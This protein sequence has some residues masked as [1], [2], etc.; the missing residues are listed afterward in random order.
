[1][2]LGMDMFEECSLL[3][4]DLRGVA[5]SLILSKW[6]S[7]CG[8]N[9]LA[10]RNFGFG[11]CSI[12]ISMLVARSLTRSGRRSLAQAKY[13]SVVHPLPSPIPLHIS[14]SQRTG[15]TPRNVV[16]PLTKP[17]T[18]STPHPKPPHPPN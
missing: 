16:Q 7:G 14:N 13:A 12:T 8:M 6:V 17:D 1:M 9:N 5:L 3:D 4:C 10:S 18:P 2:A 11:D 15:K